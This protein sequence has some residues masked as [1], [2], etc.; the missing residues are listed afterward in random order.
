MKIKKIDE[1]VNNQEQEET[2]SSIIEE[3]R[4]MDVDG[5]TM[6]YILGNVGMEDQM[7]SQL[8]T[9]YPERAILTLMDMQ[10]DKELEE[11]FIRILRENPELY[12]HISEVLF[13]ADASKYNL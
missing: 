7:L 10:D 9:T 2:I 5:E 8:I 4:N 3:L 1:W 12:K 11:I 13:K 6:Q